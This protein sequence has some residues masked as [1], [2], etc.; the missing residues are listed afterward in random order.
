MIASTPP[1]QRVLDLFVPRMTD[2]GYKYTKKWHRFKKPFAHGVFEYCVYFDGRGGLLTLDSAF[3]INFTK[4]EAL[5]KKATGTGCAWTV[6]ATLWNAGAKETRYE[7]YESTYG[8]LTP[9]EKSLIDPE[10]VHPQKRVEEAVMFLLDVH[11][12]FAQPF[13]DRMATYRQLSD[14]LFDGLRGN[15]DSFRYFFIT[16]QKLAMALLLAR[17]LGDDPSELYEIAAK[18][19]RLSVDPDGLMR[20]T[21]SFLETAS[22]ADLLLD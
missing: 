18:D 14:L 13:F 4:L 1:S 6:G 10:L 21:A 17:A 12:Q 11:D 9:K 3:F 22:P 5:Y 19:K 8:G 7:V 20:K 15:R 2:L 16:P